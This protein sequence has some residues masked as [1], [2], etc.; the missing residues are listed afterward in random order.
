MSLYIKLKK[1]EEISNR[2]KMLDILG[3]NN[4]NRISV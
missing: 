2:Y 3:N 1:L 4:N